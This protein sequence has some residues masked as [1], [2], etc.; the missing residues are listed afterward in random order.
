MLGNYRVAAQL[1]A[2]RVVIS[3]TELVFWD[4]TTPC[5]HTPEDSIL[6]SYCCEPSVKKAPFHH[7][8]VSRVTWRMPPGIDML[9]EFHVTYSRCFSVGTAIRTETIYC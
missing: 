4:M 6:H 9:S 7:G 2:S 3:S 5:G 8:K 1:V